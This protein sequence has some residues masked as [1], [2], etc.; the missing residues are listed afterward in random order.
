MV[1]PGV[2]CDRHLLGEHVECHMFVGTINA[3]KSV[4]GYLEGGLLE[5]HK[6]KRRH[7][8]LAREMEK[9]GFRHASPLPCLKKCH[10]ARRAGRI[11]VEANMA[12]LRRRCEF[13]SRR[14]L[15]GSRQRQFIRRK[16]SNHKKFLNHPSGHTDYP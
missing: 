12:E 5:I 8:V 14:Q 1:K 7:D 15:K 11:S 13:C 9:R 16:R 3:G 6:L 4:K 2:I 10:R